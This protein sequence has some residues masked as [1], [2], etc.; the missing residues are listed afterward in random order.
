MTVTKGCQCDDLILCVCEVADTDCIAITGTGAGN[1]PFV[2]SPIL[3]PDTDNILECNPS[4]LGVFLP[5]YLTNPPMIL[6]NSSVNQPIASSV[7]TIL[8]YDR[9]RYDT[10][11][12]HSEVTNTSRIVINTPG[13]YLISGW[14]IW[15]GN[16]DGERRTN[17]KLNSTNNIAQDERVALQDDPLTHPFQAYWKFSSEDYIEVEVHQNSG[18]DLEITRLSVSATYLS[19]G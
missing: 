12:M 4:G 7:T 13:V 1:D 18:V 5:T 16:P 9:E 6:A 17:V 14:V 8:F 3:D 10:D 11:S 19:T 2:A 15:S